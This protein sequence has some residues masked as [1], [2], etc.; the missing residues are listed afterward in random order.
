MQQDDFYRKILDGLYDG[1][2]LVDPDRKI[3]YWNKGAERITGY[4]AAVAV[5]HSCADKLLMHVDDAGT[6][7]CETGCPVAHTLHD[8][9]YREADVFLHHA[10]GHRVPVSVRVVPILDE[11]G[12]IT[13]A[14]ETFSDNS[15]KIAALERAS[16]LQKLALLDPLTQAGNRRFTETELTSC[17]DEYKR[18]EIPFGVIFLDMTISSR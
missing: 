1:V 17:Y 11:S 9:L 3:T 7:L 16:T 18:S 13:G 4:S 5:G 15:Q 10:D 8:G 12:K 2:Y 6:V 14:V